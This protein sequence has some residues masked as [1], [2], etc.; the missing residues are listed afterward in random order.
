LLRTLG[1]GF[2]PT[3]QEWRTTWDGKDGR[4]QRVPAGVYF[5]RLRTE[6]ETLVRKI[7]RVP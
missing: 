2:A 6:G 5:I 3:D 4:G 1:S 7:V